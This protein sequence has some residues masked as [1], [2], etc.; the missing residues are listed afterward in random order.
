MQSEIVNSYSLERG[1]NGIERETTERFRVYGFSTQESAAEFLGYFR[2]GIVSPLLFD[3][4]R[5]ARIEWIRDNGKR[6]LQ[7]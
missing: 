3:P 2:V 1:S 5:Y 6:H 4:T 7:M